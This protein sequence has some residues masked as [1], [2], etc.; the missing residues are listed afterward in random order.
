MCIENDTYITKIDD[1]GILHS[2]RIMKYINDCIS[3][4]TFPLNT[5]ERFKYHS[6][7][8]YALLGKKILKMNIH[9]PMRATLLEMF[10]DT[11]FDLDFN[12][13]TLE[14]VRQ[15]PNIVDYTNLYI[16]YKRPHEYSM[17]NKDLIMCG[18]L[19]HLR[20]LH[21]DDLELYNF[22]YYN[23]KFTVHG[24][25][26]EKLRRLVDDCSLWEIFIMVN[27][28][29]HTVCLSS[30]IDE[31]FVLN[32]MMPLNNIHHFE[33]MFIK[34]LM[35][36]IKRDDYNFIKQFV[37]KYKDCI[38]GINWKLFYKQ[39]KYYGHTYE[40]CRIAS[41]LT[42]FTNIDPYMKQIIKYGFVDQFAHVI[43][44]WHKLLVFPDNDMYFI[45]KY[46][47]FIDFEKLQTDMEF[48]KISLR[49]LSFDI[50]VRN[51]NLIP[52]ELVEELGETSDNILSRVS[53]IIRWE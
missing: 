35:N 12:K 8:N 41:F 9:D 20:N 2:D 7:I 5:M 48:Y 52:W 13:L 32:N 45:H 40:N 36:K 42:I 18:Y 15:Y 11:L 1:I 44:D 26:Y 50:I 24:I 33:Y 25:E 10:K 49:G 30:F 34:I 43:T 21:I 46:G 23:L 19:R 39:F 38:H 14:E 3:N 6:G 28:E 17:I 4:G 31:N 27:S 29:L 16:S 53:S 51:E 37:L 47:K 22:K